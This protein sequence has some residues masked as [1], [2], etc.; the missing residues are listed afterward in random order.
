VP[1]GNYLSKPGWESILLSGDAAGFADPLLG[2]GI[3]YAHKSAQLAAQA[4]LETRD[5]CR[6]TVGR[7]AELLAKRILIEMRYAKFWRTIIFSATWAFDYRVL[8]ILMNRFSR[9]AQETIQGR[10]TF[11]WLKTVDP[12]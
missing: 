3:Y 7:Y 1:Y 12:E 4:I 11:R 2:E 9:Y 6:E 10:R 8:G 5:R